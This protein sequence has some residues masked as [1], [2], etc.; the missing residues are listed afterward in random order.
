[1]VGSLWTRDYSRDGYFKTRTSTTYT[2]RIWYLPASEI[3]IADFWRT[4]DLEN[5]L[6][7]AIW[8]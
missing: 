3:V 2:E 6:A 1:M 7:K 8:T 5:I 4:P